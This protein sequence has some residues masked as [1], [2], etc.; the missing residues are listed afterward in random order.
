MPQAPG[1]GNGAQAGR[2]D[3]GRLGQHAG[4]ARA[5]AARTGPCLAQ[6]RGRL[7][8]G[9]RRTRGRPRLDP[10]RWSSARRNRGA[11]PG[12]GVSDGG[13]RLRDA[14]TL[15]APRRHG[16]VQRRPDRGRHWTRRHRRGGP[17]SARI[18][19]RHRAPARG[20]Y[21]SHDRHL[22]GRGDGDQPRLLSA[23]D[24]AA[25]D[26]HVETRQLAR[27]AHRGGGRRQ[28]VD[29]RRAGARRGASPAGEPRC[30]PRR[31]RNGARR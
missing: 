4:R 2:A 10:A 28:Q 9:P 14:G 5:G 29:H 22:S 24:T 16:S 27:R 23:G 15:P 8:A 30:R 1:E 6:S 20:W 21:R 12:G 18:R 11:V 26:D 31:V 17:R 19:P 3:D 13:D 25:A 7:R